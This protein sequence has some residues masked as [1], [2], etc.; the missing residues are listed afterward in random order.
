MDNLRSS[1]ALWRGS[2]D[3]VLSPIQGVEQ[4]GNCFAL[5]A[6]LM[7]VSLKGIN[8]LFSAAALVGG[9]FS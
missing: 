9:F 4:N 8:Q 3:V 7:H 2:C 1:G 6:K 5:S